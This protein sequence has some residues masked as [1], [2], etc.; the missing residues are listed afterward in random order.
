[1]QPSNADAPIACVDLNG[2]LDAYTG[3]KGPRHFDPP[4]EGARGIG[5]ALRDL[6]VPRAVYVSCDPATLARDLA[7]CV[8]AGYRV[9]TVRAV[10][11]FPQTHHVEGVALVA[12]DRGAG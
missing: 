1:M 10:D 8:A 9:E 6:G 11:M 7:A 2:V 4:R 5:A 12:R 3:W